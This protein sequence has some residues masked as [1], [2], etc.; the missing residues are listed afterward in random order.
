MTT[1][2]TATAQRT[3]RSRRTLRSLRRNVLPAVIGLGAALVLTL[4]SS[5]VAMAPETV[6]TVTAR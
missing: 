1:G 6:T 2:G 4:H 5:A 3:L